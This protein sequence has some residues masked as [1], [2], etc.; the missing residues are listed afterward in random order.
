MVNNYTYI[1]KMN[2][3]LPPQLN[4]HKKDHDIMTLEIQVLAWN[5]RKIVIKYLLRNCNCNLTGNY[6]WQSI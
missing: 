4:E 2:Y 6:I 5:R 1:N 3:G